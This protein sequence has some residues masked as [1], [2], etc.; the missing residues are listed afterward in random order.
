MVVS[1]RVPLYATL[2]VSLGMAIPAPVIALAD[3]P[4]TPALCSEQ[5]E[6]DADKNADT[7]AIAKCAR[8]R[9]QSAENRRASVPVPEDPEK[10]TNPTKTNI[11]TSPAVREGLFGVP[12]DNP[13]PDSVAGYKKAA[14]RAAYYTCF[15]TAREGGALYFNPAAVQSLSEEDKKDSQLA[16][17]M[18]RKAGGG[19]GKDT[20]NDDD[21]KPEL[22]TAKTAALTAEASAKFLA[23][24][25]AEPKSMPDSA[26]LE[27]MESVAVP[28][29]NL[30]NRVAAD[31][32][33][34]KAVEAAKAAGWIK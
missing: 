4:A 26:E 17:F 25:G 5:Q 6:S 20:H 18:I 16:N 8:L 15:Y 10:I 33:E 22:L 28:G 34:A 12:E 14:I 7:A 13:D 2:A 3:P 31:K 30:R 24:E 1:S 11:G 19:H 9:T 23:G 29:D 27:D 21:L 32:A